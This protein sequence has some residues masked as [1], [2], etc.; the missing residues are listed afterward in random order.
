[1]SAGANRF[2][3]S[4]QDAEKLQPKELVGLF[5]YYL[6]VEAG[7]NSASA[8][9]ID[10]CFTA[11]DLTTPSRT[12]SYL[13]EGV[14]EKKFVK[15]ER[16][17]KLQRHYREELAKMLGTGRVLVQ[18]N[19]ELR[20]LEARLPEGSTK[21]FLKETI[22]CFEAG[23][24]RAT[25]VMCWILALDH[26][27]DYV[28]QSHLPAF[29]TVLAANTNKRVKTSKVTTRDDFADIPEGM[30]IEFLRS[31]GVISADVRKLLDEKL[32]IRNSSAH[33]S[34][35]IIKK[36]KVIEFVDDLVENVIL[37]YKV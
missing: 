29:N 23:A 19:A 25:I 1:M 9:H 28:M 7:K 2:Y 12:A 35:I 14:G 24:N 8:K 6:T 22:D 21:N 32:G 11:C 13:S 15:A 18:T 30:L 33:P 36:S 31:A 20:K 3:S 10:D 34:A 16:G 17:Y 27:I 26:L 5:A 4:I 37:K